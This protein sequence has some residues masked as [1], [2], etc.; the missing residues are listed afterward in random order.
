VV[1]AE[2]F[3]NRRLVLK[4]NVETPEQIIISKMKAPELMAWMQR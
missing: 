3:F 4:L 1:M 2:H